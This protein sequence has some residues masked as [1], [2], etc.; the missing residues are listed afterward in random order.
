MYRAVT[1]KALKLKIDLDDESQYDFL[2]DTEIVLTSDSRVL[3][4]GEDVTT[5]IR[6]HE[7]TQTSSG[8]GP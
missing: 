4:D 3:I 8:I 7:V 1:Y 5:I 2:D 6:E